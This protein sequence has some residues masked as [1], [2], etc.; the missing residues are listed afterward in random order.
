LGVSGAQAI[1]VINIITVTSAGSS[2]TDLSFQGTFVDQAVPQGL[3]LIYVDANGHNQTFTALYK[4]IASFNQG[5]GSAR[6][7]LNVSSISAPICQNITTNISFSNVV[8]S[9]QA[10]SPPIWYGTITNY[11]YLLPVGWQLGSSVSDGTTWLSGTNNVL[12]TSDGMH[13]DG[14]TVQVRA[15]ACTPGISPGPAASISIS[16]GVPS[17]SISGSGL[18]CG[19]SGNYSINTVP[20]GASIVW[21]VSSNMQIVGSSTSS[22]V[23][24]QQLAGSSSGPGTITATIAYS[25]GAVFSAQKSVL[26]GL[27]ETVTIDTL[28]VVCQSS[29]V[30]DLWIQV[31]PIPTATRYYYYSDGS[32]WTSNTSSQLSLNGFRKD[33]RVHLIAVVVQ[34]PCGNVGSP[35]EGIHYSSAACGGGN[36]LLHDISPNPA[37]SSVLVTPSRQ[38]DMSVDPKQKIITGIKIYDMT[39][40]VR[41]LAAYGSGV[42]QVRLDIHDL[43]AGLYFMEISNGKDTERRTLIVRQH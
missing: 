6:P 26:V 10:V 1:Q 34:T 24:I 12:V 16:R 9:D 42:E 41:K 33:N 36:F 17:F 40:R 25:C 31:H 11:Q 35:T 20:T 13:G 22:T 15:A 23:S 5:D 2:G 14:G 19:S 30:Y 39:G 43:S 28:T 32:L 18:V 38:L 4:N 8:Y 27:P 3:Q 21:S 7:A 37:S 29:T